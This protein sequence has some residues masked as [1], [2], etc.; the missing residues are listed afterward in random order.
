MA[1]DSC[2]SSRTAPSTA[3]RGQS[4]QVNGCERRRK[5]GGEILLF[6][7]MQCRSFTS[8]CLY[9]F[10]VMGEGQPKECMTPHTLSIACVASQSSFHL[11]LVPHISPPRPP[12]CFHF[13]R[14]AAV[15]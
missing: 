13:S 12:L 2:S 8:L 14:S 3:G 10:E 1:T 7:L 15:P 5:G 6:H 11:S 9:P 4:S